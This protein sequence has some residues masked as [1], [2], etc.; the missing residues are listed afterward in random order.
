ERRARTAQ[1]GRRVRMGAGHARERCAR[2][3]DRV[4]LRSLLTA[5]C[6]AGGVASPGTDDLHA[7][8]LGCDLESTC[9]IADAAVSVPARLAIAA[10]GGNPVPGTASTLGMRVPGSPRWSLALRSTLARAH[11][12]PIIG[13]DHTP[14]FWSIG[15][16]A[17]IGI[18][19]GF[20]LLPTI[21]GFGSIDALG[22]FGV[23]SVPEG[24]GFETDS[25]VT[26]AIGARVG[27]RRES[28]TAP[29]VS[30]SAMYRSLPDLAYAQDSTASFANDDQS[31]MTYRA[32]VGK[33]ILGV[34]L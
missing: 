13:T 29:G 4:R 12:P 14:A 15:A 8:T 34:G 21:G 32:T 33:R 2:G 9:S 3:G 30:V 11:I 19:N 10:T 20:M 28:Y 7:Q 27:I 25:P 26:W 31:V 24:D 17:S 18:F 23:L 22:S 16:D 6:I 1:G 5:A